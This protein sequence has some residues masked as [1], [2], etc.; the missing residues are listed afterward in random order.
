MDALY[1]FMRITDDFADEP[2]RVA[3]K[4]P[5]LIEWRR[6]LDAALQGDYS[7]PLHTA[8]HDIVRNYRIPPEYLH[9]VIDGVETDLEPVRFATFK[10]L[11]GYCYR[12]AS[13]VGLCC[14]HIW[15]FRGVEAKEFAIANGIALQLTNILRDLAEDRQEGRIYLPE[16][17]LRRFDAPPERWQVDCPQFQALMRFQ[18]ERAKQYY[19]EGAKLEPFLSPEGRAVFRTMTGIYRELLDTIVAKKFDVFGERVRLTRWQK[20]RWL[21]SAF[22]HR[23]G[24][25]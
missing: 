21:L 12:V 4:R 23:W 17:D 10:E 8:L 13:V 1:A 22:P 9:A 16:E 25:T 19:A 18:V 20:I 2:A 24:W 11:E 5:T 7:H 6:S 14:I 3:E 15:G